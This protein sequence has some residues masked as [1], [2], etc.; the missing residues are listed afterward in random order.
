MSEQNALQ[1]LLTFAVKGVGYWADMAN[2]ISVTDEEVDKYLLEA[3]AAIDSAD[4]NALSA[5]AAKAPDLQKKIKGMFEKQ[6]GRAFS[7]FVPTA[8]K[9][10][11][12]T[13][14][15][16]EQVALGGQVDNKGRAPNDILAIRETT[17][18]NLKKLAVSGKATGEAMAIVKQG[19]TF[20][21]HDKVEKEDFDAY[22][23]AL[24]ALL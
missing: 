7:G 15:R 5:L 13:E 10:L 24:A 4:A 17:F 6:N 18:A 21:I 14:D 22:A 3:L 19:L 8:G 2:S 23:K 11:Q 12:I 1:N 9:A 16:A 20:Q